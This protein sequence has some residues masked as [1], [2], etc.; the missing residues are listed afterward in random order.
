MVDL[1]PEVVAEDLVEHIPDV[2][3]GADFGCLD[4]WAAV[5][6]RTW[7]EVWKYD[8]IPGS[9]V[10]DWQDRAVCDKSPVKLYEF[11]PATGANYFKVKGLVDGWR[12]P[13]PDY[14]HLKMVYAPIK[15]SP[16][17]RLTADSAILKIDNRYSFTD[18][19]ELKANWRLLRG[20]ETVKSGAARLKLAPRTKGEVELQL[21][22]AIKSA[23][24]LR[25]DF[26]H[27]DGRNI[28]SHEFRLS[29]APSGQIPPMSLQL[30]EG[31]KFP[32]FNLV[33][34][35]TKG[36]PERWRKITRYRGSLINVKTDPAGNEDLNGRLLRDIRS[37]EADI[38]LEKAPSEVVGHVKAEYADGKFS[39]RIDWTGEK[40]D[41]QELGWSFEMPHAFDRFSWKRRALWSVY[42]DTHIGRPTGT[43]LPDSANVHYT[44]ISRPDAFD[45]NS[46][47]YHC[48]W[49]S[50]TDASEHG[51]RIEFAPEQRHHARGGF[52]EKG[53]YRL[54]VN[55]QCSPP[56]DISSG[57]VPDFYLVLT[58]GKSIEGSF[59]VGSQ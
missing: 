21:G 53:A 38:F 1:H 15:V 54:I 47:K 31:L 56:R 50:L 52:G 34:N 58:E 6:Q 28:V 41:I 13:R 25:I 10:W 51:L 9:F 11:D 35:E 16:E 45:F 32:R 23:D 4:L 22:D 19:A 8:T 33:T 3:L 43:A 39:Y 30:S 2:R 20:G 17:V 12:N 29:P 42:P 37:M 40:A 27:A 57:T 49:A 46:T 36:D 24:A 26:D 7:D 5:L 18:L 48:D 44:N 14:Y 59:Y 55:K